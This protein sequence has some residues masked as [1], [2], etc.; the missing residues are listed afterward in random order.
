[1]N[2]TERSDAWRLSRT[3]NLFERKC[4]FFS[5]PRLLLTFTVRS[6]DL[7]FLLLR[8]IQEVCNLPL[9]KSRN[10]KFFSSFFILDAFESVQLCS[11]SRCYAHSLSLSCSD[12]NVQVSLSRL[13]NFWL[14]LR[15]V[16]SVG[17]SQPIAPDSLIDNL[18]ISSFSLCL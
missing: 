2:P 11:F 13:S 3:A 4:N 15:L 14:A 8:Q 6:R 18:H 7:Q 17:V 16:C 12:G 9:E 1:M 5:L 10:Q